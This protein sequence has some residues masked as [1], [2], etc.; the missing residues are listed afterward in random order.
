MFS[1]WVRRI[2]DSVFKVH[3][4]T[5]PGRG[6]LNRHSFITSMPAR[7]A[8][9]VAAAVAERPLPVAFFGASLGC[10][11]AYETAKILLQDTNMDEKAKVEILHLFVAGH[12]A[13]EEFA[14]ERT[15]GS[16]SISSLPDNAFKHALLKYNLVEKALLQDDD[17]SSLFLPIIR[18][19]LQLDES[20]QFHPKG[21]KLTCPVTAFSGAVDVAAMPD[22][23]KPWKKISLQGE[24]TKHVIFPD[25]GHQFLLKCTES[26]VEEICRSLLSGPLMRPWHELLIRQAYLAPNLTAITH[27]TGPG[28]TP[29]L[30]MREF[31]A[32]GH[33][34]ASRLWAGGVRRHSMVMM[35]VPSSYLGVLT[36]FAVNICGGTSVAVDPSALERDIRTR[37]SDLCPKAIVIAEKKRS[38]MDLAKLPQWALEAHKDGVLVLQQGEVFA[39]VASD[40]A[41]I[42]SCKKAKFAQN[43]PDTS[44]DEDHSTRLSL[45]SAAAS[46][47]EDSYNPLIRYG[48]AKGQVMCE[49]IDLEDATFVAYTSGS[50]GL[51]KGMP[52][53]HR[54]VANN[55]NWR[56]FCLRM[57]ESEVFALSIFWWWYW[58]VPMLQG[59]SI[60]MVA[61]HILIDVESLCSC[62]AQRKISSLDLTPSLLGEVLRNHGSSGELQA[63]RRVI[64]YGEPLPLEVCRLFHKYLPK[65]NLVNL[66][67]TTENNDLTYCKVTP[68][69]VKMTQ[70]SKLNLTNAP[71]G[72]L[73]WNVLAHLEP[74]NREEEEEDEEMQ[75]ETKTDEKDGQTIQKYEFFAYGI[76]LPPGYVRRPEADSK[77][78]VTINGH[79][80]YRCGDLIALC[81]GHMVVLGRADQVV[82][83]RGFRVGLPEV[84]AALNKGPGVK[85]A[86]PVYHKKTHTLAAF[87]VFQ[88]HTNL[89]ALREHLTQTLEKQAVPTK[90]I[91][92]R[93]LPKNHRGKLDK[94]QM[95]N[96]LNNGVP[97][98]YRP[99]EQPTSLSKK[100]FEGDSKSFGPPLPPP[101]T[102]TPPLRPASKIIQN[103][104]SMG[105][106]PGLDVC[107][108]EVRGV[109]MTV[110]GLDEEMKRGLNLDDDFF[111][112]GGHS[113]LVIKLAKQLGL[114]MP[115]IMSERTLLG[116][117]RLLHKKRKENKALSTT[118]T[119]PWDVGVIEGV[120]RPLGSEYRHV[121]IA[122]VGLSGRYPGAGSPG[123]FWVNLQGNSDCF[124]ELS[125]EEMRAA[126]VRH[127]PE[128]WVA[129]AA[130]IPPHLVRNFEPALFGIGM[131]EARLT[132]PN[133]R[134]LLELAYE[135]LED[136]GYDP[137]TVGRE[138]EKHGGVGV[139]M[140][141]PSLPTY[142]LNCVNR[143][144]T[145]MM[146][147]HPGEYVRAELGNDKDYIAPRISFCLGLSGPSRTIQSACSSSMVCIVEAVEA[148]R[149]G[150]CSLAL[151]GGISVQCP[152]KSGYLYQDG[153]VLSPDGHVRPFDADARGTIF[154]NGGAVVG[155]KSLARAITDRDHIY[156]VIRGVADNNDGRREK[157]FFAAPSA[158]GQADVVT[159]ALKDASVRPGDVG[160]V[161]AHGTGT[162]VGDPIE[163][164]GLCRVFGPDA[165][166]APKRRQ[167]CALGSVKG[168]IGHPN[169]AAGV[170]ALSKVLLMLHEKKIVPTANYVVPNPAIDFATSPFYPAKQK[171]ISWP[172]PPSGGPRY[173]CISA[174]G[175]GGTNAHAVLEEYRGEE[176]SR[177]ITND[178]VKHGG[179]T[180]DVGM[181]HTPPFLF[182]LAARTA[183]SLTETR[184]KLGQF[185]ERGGYPVPGTPPPHHLGD[186]AFTLACGRHHYQEYRWCTVA[187]TRDEACQKFRDAKGVVSVNQGTEKGSGGTDGK[188][189][190]PRVI[191]MFSGQGSQYEGMGRSL[192]GHFPAF[193][194]AIDKCSSIVGY[195]VLGGSG[196]PASSTS[197][198]AQVSVF[199]CSYA[200]GVLMDQVGIE[201]YAVLGHSAGE[202]AAAVR[203]GVMGLESA[204][205]VLD[206]RG[207]ILD[208]MK[209]GAMLTVFASAVTVQ[210]WLKEGKTKFSDCS[211]ACDNAPDRVVVSGPRQQLTVLQQTLQQRD[212][213]ARAS[214]LK[215]AKA[216][217]SKFVETDLLGEFRDIVATITLQ[218]PNTRMLCN[219]TGTWLD[220]TRATDPE[221]WVEQM[222]LPVQ[223]R[224]NVEVVL[225]HAHM[226][227]KSNATDN[228]KCI[229][230]ELGPG[231]AL[232]SL[233]RRCFTTS[234]DKLN[235]NNN[236]NPPIHASFSLGKHPKDTSDDASVFLAAVGDL[237][238]S[239]VNVEWK[240]LFGPGF[241][242]GALPRRISMPTYAFNRSECWIGQTRD[243]PNPPPPSSPSQMV[244]QQHYV[245]VLVPSKTGKEEGKG[246]LERARDTKLPSIFLEAGHS[247]S[248][249][250]FLEKSGVFELLE[251]LEPDL[252]DARTLRK[253]IERGKLVILGPDHGNAEKDK[254]RDG[255]DDDEDLT[256]PALYLLEIL[257]RLS[258]MLE[259]GSTEELLHVALIVSPDNL[260]M[261]GAWGIAKVAALE[262]SG[263]MKLTRVLWQ[264]GSLPQ[265]LSVAFAGTCPPEIRVH[266]GES[267]ELSVH[268]PRLRRI[269]LPR[270]PPP[271]AILRNTNS[272]S[273][274]KTGVW[275]VTGGTRGIGLRM[276]TYLV[277]E[278]GI[279]CMVLVS[280]MG[281]PADTP[282]EV[283]EMRLC[284]AIVTF[285]SADVTQAA[286]VARVLTRARQM[287]VLRGVVHSAGILDDGVLANAEKARVRKVML[288]KTSAWTIHK[289]TMDDDL[290]AMILF[291]S[292]SSLF[293]V[294]GQG[295]YIAAN[296]FLDWLADK[297]NSEGKMTMSVQWGAWAEV[298]MSVDSNLKEAKGE[299]HMSPSDALRAFSLSLDHA[300]SPKAP[301]AAGIRILGGTGSNRDVGNTKERFGSARY[302]VVQI[303]DWRS[304]AR[305]FEEQGVGFASELTG[306]INAYTPNIAPKT[307]VGNTDKASVVAKDMVSVTKGENAGERGGREI[308]NFLREN[309]KLGGGVGDPGVSLGEAGFD[310]LDV[311]NL[312]NAIK[313]RFRVTLP[314]DKFF[315]RSLSLED[316]ASALE[317]RH[318]RR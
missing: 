104:P 20:Y 51:P 192:Y 168:H 175:M 83:V 159:R 30:S 35:V 302:A 296:T 56:M 179:G 114:T 155:L 160:Y 62:I 266:S 110:L 212:P 154:T 282:P 214:L 43:K 142:L 275:V 281:E 248:R 131:G 148:I 257:Q 225:K 306:K 216:F 272:D 76:A 130:C 27:H 106:R 313:S 201:P 237:W 187:K 52:L 207:A 196:S 167:W 98:D 284:G 21:S 210:N 31:V 256:S 251:P 147:Y 240:R 63:I 150:R 8:K 234:R 198:W 146:L 145:D 111:E 286:D 161:E 141:G 202:Y 26:L 119:T 95:I 152:Q 57:D 96:F 229:F 239:G 316:L 311:I 38:G 109:W 171:T 290:D 129:R 250:A 267:K 77:A 274:G 294:A 243:L 144:L 276:A 264:G 133:Q 226:E 169:T 305:T 233:A 186:V 40:E 247:A 139:F 244:Y 23:M 10:L 39:L 105:T 143:N 36:M 273:D 309:V 32:Q 49:A 265:V 205:N 136:A 304:Y 88:G 241:I 91:P 262:Y 54:N 68:D 235:K 134:M 60:T 213:P 15:S 177:S 242:S 308:L 283:K 211:L 184:K 137:F 292:T 289:L 188:G 299:K 200:M 92:L 117:A 246:E 223:F 231:N 307:P 164:Q 99:S 185:L 41:L 107:V 279:R 3:T 71:I 46:V 59:A 270:S 191:F 204:L 215:T 245:P 310:S 232:S 58:F 227:T 135:C 103:T 288:V 50:T 238:R 293:G 81:G 85:E 253:A 64:C 208:K 86:F 203:S 47:P 7:C 122:I 42:D 165:P 312:R 18:A 127:V 14:K 126:G 90:L 94:T 278:R 72:V 176:H 132:D 4:L 121:P 123:E 222:R 87:V 37:V 1:P 170:C 12:V 93:R 254:G 140:A 183:S 138:E 230:V 295:S 9:E 65:A 249:K 268:V 101:S 228:G 218:K 115:Q 153:M 82:N 34:L 73:C 29:E 172:Q 189:S 287:G 193:K 280:R 300:L 45:S 6:R 174:F 55:C 11:V 219:A 181:L 173:A 224:Q 221:R 317:S 13:P 5:L 112:V 209:E 190:T 163:F 125:V 78:F 194:A 124:Q 33:R 162:L 97:S 53:S 149:R 66:Y 259:S 89:R 255:D 48:E 128:G 16:V 269:S 102:D 301:T 28:S 157:Q 180:A 108:E 74:V 100:G 291:S 2:P 297:R 277:R 314:L 252:K 79:K 24:L 166:A 151:A 182:V 158:T 118:S 303:T 156:A 271:R 75:R 70:N 178:G 220:P 260:T 84:S 315:D 298:G 261:A 236:N 116:Q 217:H 263:D 61:P 206:R 120:P 80:M 22:R 69:L 285:E 67:S 25:M 197:R 19:D 258:E 113:I 199:A 17:F 318:Q 44:N 195:P